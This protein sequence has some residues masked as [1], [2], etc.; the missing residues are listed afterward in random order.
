MMNSGEGKFAD[1]VFLQDAISRQ[2]KVV[3]QQSPFEST[4]PDILTHSPAR[5]SR[6][7]PSAKDE[8]KSTVYLTCP[9]QSLVG[10]AYLDIVHSVMTCEDYSSKNH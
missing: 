1:I 9:K 7:R 3:W 2:A 8:L 10:Q 6:K 5:W 4:I